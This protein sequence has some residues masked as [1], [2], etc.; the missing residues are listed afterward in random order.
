MPGDRNPFEQ[1]GAPDTSGVVG[2][3]QVTG[4]RNGT[5]LDAIIAQHRAS[6]ARDTRRNAELARAALRARTEPRSLRAA[7]V[8]AQQAGDAPAVIAEVK[9]AT[10]SKGPLVADLDPAALAGEYARGGAAAISVLTDQPNFAGSPD[11]LAA[12]RAASELPT[13]RKDFTVAVADI[14]DA[15]IMGA[16]AI[17]LIAAALFDHEM[18]RFAQVADELGLDVLFEAHDQAEIERCIAAG[19]TI[20]GVN[21]RDLVTFDVDTERA[22]A[23]APSIPPAVVSVA[24]SGIRDAAD[25]KRLAAAGYAAVLVGETLVRSD[26]PAD[27]IV[28][29]RGGA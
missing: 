18:A 20:V 13:L 22:C 11:D 23:V 7:I 8:A 2:N 28:R 24:E 5:Y 29:L 12:A 21:Q 3:G 9:R 14:Y 19:A 16:D 27:E 26:D 6:A 25:A 15:A 4:H 10:P 1:S 17:L